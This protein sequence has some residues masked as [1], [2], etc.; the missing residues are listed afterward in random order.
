[1]TK[2]HQKT[3]TSEREASEDSNRVHEYF[4]KLDAIIRDES[5]VADDIWNMDETGLHKNSSN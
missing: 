4:T 1:M 3:L 2:A 5:F